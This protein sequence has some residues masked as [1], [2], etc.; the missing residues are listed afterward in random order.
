MLP[1]CDQSKESATKKKKRPSKKQRRVS[2]DEEPSQKNVNGRYGDNDRYGDNGY[3]DDNG[4]YG[5]NGRYGDSVD[6]AD[7]DDRSLED[8]TSPVSHRR[9]DSVPSDPRRDEDDWRVTGS[10]PPIS[11]RNADH[12]ARHL[13][14]DRPTES[15]RRLTENEIS[16]RLS[17]RQLSDNS[18]GSAL[19]GPAGKLAPVGQLEPLSTG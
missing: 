14:S 9:D 18:N 19:L 1:N 10:L 15:Y 8:R 13:N 4:H 16:S 5:D 2:G 7:A 11:P 17:D 12:S 6:P 3:Y